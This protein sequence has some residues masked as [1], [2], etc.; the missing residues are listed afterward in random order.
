M[1]IEKVAGQKKQQWIVSEEGFCYYET[2]GPSMTDWAR[3]YSIEELLEIQTAER[4][5]A[6][7]ADLPED[8][9][10]L[11]GVLRQVLSEGAPTKEEGLNR[12]L[13]LRIQAAIEKLSVA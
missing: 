11:V 10:G 9:G 6:F 12:E 2:H 3:Q 13:Q 5:Q 7:E 4:K 8:L 1:I